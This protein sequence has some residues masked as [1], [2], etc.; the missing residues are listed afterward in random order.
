MSLAGIAISIG[1]LVDSSVVMAENAMHP[2]RL[3]LRHARVRGDVG[4]VACRPAGR[5]GGRSFSRWRIMVLSFL[6]VLPGRD[7]AED[8]PP[9]GRNEI[10]CPGGGGGPV[11]H[12]GA[13]L[14]LPLDPWPAA[15]EMESPLIRG[16]DRGVSAGALYLMDRPAAL[17]WVIGL[18]FV[19]GSRRLAAGRI[20][21]ATLSP[22]P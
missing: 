6:P 11:D 1:V 2:L 21:L 12:A 15:G 17:A 20:F 9:V 7:G 22:R 14:L 18:T 16:V 10:V 13:G 19:P 8:V 4:D 5:W 3:S